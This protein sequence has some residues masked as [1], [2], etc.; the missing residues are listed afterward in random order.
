MKTCCQTEVALSACLTLAA[1]VLLWRGGSHE[2]EP[3]VMAA[4][5]RT[6]AR[7]PTK[8][9][10]TQSS[11]SV[12]NRTPELSSF[13]TATVV[14]IYWN[15]GFVVLKPETLAVAKGDFAFFAHLPKHEAWVRVTGADATHLVADL[16]GTDPNAVKCGDRV[17]FSK[18][19]VRGGDVS[20]V[21]PSQIQWTDPDGSGWVD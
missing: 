20:T 2:A 1:L 21:D 15:L 6:R 9:D 7:H 12:R 19:P 13:P 16:G 4:E 8:S 18:R 10:R 3:V 17:L 11:R 5:E 14:D